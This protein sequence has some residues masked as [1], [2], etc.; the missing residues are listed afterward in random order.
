MRNLPYAKLTEQEKEIVDEH[1]NYCMNAKD[2]DCKKQHE[3]VV[4]FWEAHREMDY[5]GFTE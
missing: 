2:M 1:Y 5:E 4:D 3:G